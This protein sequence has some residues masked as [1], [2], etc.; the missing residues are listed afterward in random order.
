[1]NEK[2]IAVADSS[3]YIVLAIYDI[4]DNKRRQRMV[5]CLSRY[6][7]RVQNPALKEFLRRNNVCKWRNLPVG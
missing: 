1:M 5:K 4:A 6:A 2:D 3:R 7:V